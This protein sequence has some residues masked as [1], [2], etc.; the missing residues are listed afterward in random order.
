ME[1]KK[2]TAY[3]N[4]EYGKPLFAIKNDGADKDIVKFGITKAEAILSVV[5]DL[6]K[7]VESQKKVETPAEQPATPK[8][9][10]K[11]ATG[12]HPF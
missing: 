8:K 7:Y 11:K 10:T 9:A 12:D 1:I 4:T 6:K 2:A 5:D 3:I